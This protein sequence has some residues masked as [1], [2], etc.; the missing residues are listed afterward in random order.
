[1]TNIEKTFN[2]YGGLNK[3]KVD[4]LKEDEGTSQ[5]KLGRMGMMGG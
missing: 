3:N 1:M 2:Q 5:N 4:E